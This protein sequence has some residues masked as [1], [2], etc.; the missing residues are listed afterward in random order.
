MRQVHNINESYQHYYHRRYG[1]SNALIW[2]GIFAF[3]LGMF[4]Y[5]L[6]KLNNPNAENIMVGIL[7]IVVGIILFIIG[8]VLKI[9]RRNKKSFS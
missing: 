7:V 2:A 9:S 5:N 6:F 4:T 8:I 1:F 3:S